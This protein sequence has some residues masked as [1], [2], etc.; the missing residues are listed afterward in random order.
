MNI[1]ELQKKLLAVARANPPSDNVPYLF[2]KRVMAR[3]S[4]PRVPDAWTCWER[5]LWRA[6][7]PCV[8]IMLVV[9]L[10][11][12]FSQDKNSSTVPLEVALENTLVASF[13]N[14]GEVW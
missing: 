12:F 8:A 11:S 7:A 5:A 13:E 4:M 9:G 3:L 14:G 10:L 1:A 6:A 2:E